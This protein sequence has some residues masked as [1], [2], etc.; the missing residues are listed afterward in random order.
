MR[1]TLAWIVVYPDAQEVLFGPD[2][3]PPDA[4]V[5]GRCPPM[6]WWM[7]PA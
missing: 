4:L 1:P 7:R 5:A 2:F 3:A 6:W